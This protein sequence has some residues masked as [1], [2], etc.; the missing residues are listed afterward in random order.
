MTRFSDRIGATQPRQAFQTTDMDDALRNSLWN[1]LYWTLDADE[2]GR[3]FVYWRAAARDLWVDVLKLPIDTV[4][5]DPTDTVKD[6]LMSASWYAVY[7]LIEYLLPRLDGYRGSYD[8]RGAQVIRRRLNQYLEREMSGFRAVGD[9]L[10]PVTSPVEIVEIERA[11]TP[12]Q[13]MEAVAMHI[14][15]ALS[16]LG[17]KPDPDYRNSIKESISAVESAAKLLTG[18]TSGGIDPAL[19]VLEKKGLHPALKSA[20]SKLYG[21]TSDKGGI[22]HAHAAL[23][24][25]NVTEP[26]AR[27][28]LVACSAFA[29]LLISA[30]AST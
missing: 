21:Y 8:K 16:L 29:N 24:A 23:E 20:L 22:R 13:G 6:W 28:M 30:A 26:E 10:V 12:K 1:W 5:L 4:P 27:F 11:A 17:K 7:N 18:E 15:N 2:T 3:K 25:P 14:G 19:R 9:E